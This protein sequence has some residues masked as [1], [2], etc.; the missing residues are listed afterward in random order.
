MRR[1]RSGSA[2]SARG[3]PG[4]GATPRPRRTGRPPRGRRTGRPARPRR[5]RRPSGSARPTPGRRRAPRRRAGSG[6]PVASASSSFVAS[7]PSST[8]SR[9]AA[10]DSFCWRSTTCTGHADRARVV[11]HGALHRLADPPGRVRR[12]LVAAPPV[13]LLDGAVE[14]ERALL[15]QVEE[16]DAEPAVALG[17][18]DDEPEVRLDHAPLGDAGRRARLPSRA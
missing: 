3:R 8:S 13:E 17:D 4:G 12:E 15:D 5:P 1:S 7:R 2:S 6:R 11:R 14:A 9:R 16:R 10:R 18:R